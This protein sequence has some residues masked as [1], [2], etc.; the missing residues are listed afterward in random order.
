MMKRTVFVI[1]LVFVVCFGAGLV[2]AFDATNLQ[3][4]KS[5]KVCSECD[6]SFAKLPRMIMQA[7]RFPLTNFSFASLSQSDFSKSFGQFANFHGAN[8]ASINLQNSD[9]FGANFHGA[10]LYGA[11]LYGAKLGGANLSDANLRAANL[12]N[13]NL[14]GANLAGAN[15]S[16]ATL[17]GA[18]WS[19]GTTCKTPSVGVCVK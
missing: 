8:M 11:N 5:T 12:A 7:S 9:L 15:F 18:T 13:A 2:Y 16:N 19:D 4:Y 10:N 3:T 1:C 17:S 14:T 6:L